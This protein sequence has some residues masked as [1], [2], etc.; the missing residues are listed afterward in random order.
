MPVATDGSINSAKDFG[1]RLL[2]VMRIVI[3]GI[4][5]IYLVMIGVYMILGSDSEET[6]K[7]QRKQITY[8]LI[9]FLFLNIP[10]FVYTIFMPG[11]AS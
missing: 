10:G 1:F 7:T 11:Q 8:A 5:L 6:V 4:A 9:G 2:G 3:S